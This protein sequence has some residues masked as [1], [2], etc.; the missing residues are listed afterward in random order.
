[1]GYKYYQNKN[2]VANHPQLDAGMPDF[3]KQEIWN[4]LA[5]ENDPVKLQAIALSLTQAGYP[6]A[7]AQVANKALQII[8]ARS[9]GQQ[10]TR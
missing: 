5:T 1:M 3:N 6:I 4:V 10:L 7:A 9:V 8:Q 2:Q